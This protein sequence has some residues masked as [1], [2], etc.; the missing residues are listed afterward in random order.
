MILCSV[1]NEYK[2]RDEFSRSALR[3]RNRCRSCDTARKKA[4]RERQPEDYKPKPAPYK[5]GTLAKTFT[6]GKRCW[7]CRRQATCEMLCWKCN[8]GVTR[9]VAAWRQRQQ[10]R[11]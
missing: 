5:F 1:C 11:G 7:C 9:A 10:S 6:T 4:W 8:G 2:L 3:T